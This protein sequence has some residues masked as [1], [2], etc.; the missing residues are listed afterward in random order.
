MFN[1]EKV[2]KWALMAAK[3]T[4]TST[5]L[6]ACEF[7]K[8]EKSPL[9]KLFS[10]DETTHVVFP[11]QKTLRK[12]T[13]CEGQKKKKRYLIRKIARSY[14]SFDFQTILKNCRINLLDRIEIF[15]SIWTFGHI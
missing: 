3:A 15:N 14:K 7:S 4:T 9:K 6:T 13:I 12:A 1:E 11:A 2:K 5:K 10:N 8:K